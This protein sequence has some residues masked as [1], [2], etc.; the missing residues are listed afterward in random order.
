MADK[1]S[2]PKAMLVGA[3]AAWLGAASSVYRIVN[4]LRKQEGELLDPILMTVIFVAA[5]VAFTIQYR[6]SKQDL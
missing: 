5:A 3:I 2:F 6:N 1:K 4:N